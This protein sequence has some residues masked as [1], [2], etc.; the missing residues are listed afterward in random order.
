MW[1]KNQLVRF[2]NF[3]SNLKRFTEWKGKATGYESCPIGPPKYEPFLGSH[4]FLLLIRLAPNTN[5]NVLAMTYYYLVQ[6]SKVLA[7][8]G[9]PGMNPADQPTT[10]NDLQKI[11]AQP[12]YFVSSH[13]SKEDTGWF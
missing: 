7:S 9:F 12:D 3:L 4:V 1:L 5:Y 8:P 11:I 10:S 2:L 6:L 13:T